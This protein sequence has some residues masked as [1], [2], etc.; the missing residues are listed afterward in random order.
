[1]TIYATPC[2]NRRTLEA[3][4]RI[5]V[6]IIIREIPPMS[7]DTSTSVPIAQTELEGL[8]Q[9]N[10][11]LGVELGDFFL[12]LG[13]P[14]GASLGMLRLQSGEVVLHGGNFLLSTFCLTSER[15]R[16]KTVPPIASMR[17]PTGVVQSSSIS[18][19]TANRFGKKSLVTLSNLKR[20]LP[21]AMRRGAWERLNSSLGSSHNCQHFLRVG[22]ILY[23]I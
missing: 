13:F 10:L 18:A 15:A 6:V 8:L 2:A 3:P 17:V 20:F 21:V 11:D 4:Y 1:M 9:L 22:D 19:T 23:S 12:E 14:V 16:W 7:T 5:F